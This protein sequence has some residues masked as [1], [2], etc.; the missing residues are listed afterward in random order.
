MSLEALLGGTENFYVAHKSWPATLRDSV[1]PKDPR[2]RRGGSLCRPSGLAVVFQGALC[3]PEFICVAQK[4]FCVARRS[5]GRH[6]AGHL[7]SR[8]Q[9]QMRRASLLN[10]GLK[11]LAQV[12]GLPARCSFTLEAQLTP[13]AG[14]RTPTKPAPRAGLRRLRA[15]IRDGRWFGPGGPLGHGLRDGLPRPE[16]SSSCG[17]EAS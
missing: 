5:F 2:G 16:G 10:C 17:A 14:S 3:R 1:S 7:R 8:R 9:H 11:R 15:R 6:R 4:V 13:P 12:E